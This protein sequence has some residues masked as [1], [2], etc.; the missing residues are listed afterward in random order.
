MYL[1]KALSIIAYK[2]SLLR[3]WV[4]LYTQLVVLCSISCLTSCVVCVWSQVGRHCSVLSINKTY[5]QNAPLP[6]CVCLWFCSTCHAQCCWCGTTCTR[7][8]VPEASRCLCMLYFD[9]AFLLYSYLCVTLRLVIS[10]NCYGC[11]YSTPPCML[12]SYV[13]RA[14]PCRRLMLQ[15][16]VRVL[17]CIYS[18]CYIHLP[19]CVLLVGVQRA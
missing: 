4:R 18:V 15:V 16:C 9:T 2:L 17:L 8:A 3:F 5:K 10:S 1:H 13:S 12:Q 6:C 11:F 7:A 14:L 19:L